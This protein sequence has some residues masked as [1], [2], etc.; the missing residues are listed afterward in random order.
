MSDAAKL[1][2]TGFLG[3]LLGAG[4][5]FVVLFD[6]AEDKPLMPDT[7]E[8][9]EAAGTTPAPDAPPNDL[10]AR[11]AERPDAPEEE[12]GEREPIAPSGTKDSTALEKE[13]AE[14]KE[15]VA[16]LR[17]KLVNAPLIPARSPEVFRF[18]LSEKTPSFDKADWKDLSTHMVALAPIIK[19]IFEP[20]SRGEQPSPSAIQKAQKH[21]MPLAVF[22]VKAAEEIE[23]TGPNGSFTH[24]AV[25]ANLIRAALENVGDPLTETQE[26]SIRTLGDAWATDMKR[27][28]AQFGE[29]PILLEKAVYEV[30]AK[31]RFLYSVKNAL[32]PS[33]REFLFNPGTEGRVQMDLLSPA[34]VYVMRR[35]LQGDS[36]EDLEKQLLDVIFDVAGLEDVQK[37]AFDWIARQWLDDYP[38]ALVPLE[39]TSLDF[40]APHVDRIQEAARAEVAVIKQIISVGGLDEE[41]VKALKEITTVLMPQLMKVPG[42]GGE[43]D[44]NK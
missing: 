2:I 29:N 4:I 36:R 38:A 20:I 25:V 26:I 11:G 34:L 37:E 3:A 7:G 12:T 15:L 14:L 24:P 21:N 27:A 33:Q 28:E 44:E 30:D 39:R 35:P 23:G 19:D 42:G 17:K 41:K 31:L 18:G 13:N 10:P 32:T 8:T 16:D 40:I 5:I 6:W 9:E 43:G 1:G 22:A